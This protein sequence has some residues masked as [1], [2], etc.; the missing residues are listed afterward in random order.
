MKT[1]DGSFLVTVTSPATPSTLIVP[2]LT[3]GVGGTPGGWNGGYL[4]TCDKLVVTANIS[5]GTGGTLDIMMQNQVA[6]NVWFDWA[7]LQQAAAGGTFS[8]VFTVDGSG[9]GAGNI[10][11]VTSGTDVSAGAL[12]LAAGLY[13]N[14]LPGGPVRL[15]LLA[16]AGTTVGGTQ[17][18]WFTPYREY[19]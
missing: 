5:G 18:I 7:R 4:T 8:I 16:G 13:T 15:I 19:R 14:A 10:K 3:G 11:L 1:K 2:I 6:P 17:N 12:G 9:V